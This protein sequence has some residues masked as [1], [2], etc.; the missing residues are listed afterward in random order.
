[1]DEE[2]RKKIELILQDELEL[3]DLTWEELND[4]GE[5]R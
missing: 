5:S 4:Y 2:F 3:H 1:M